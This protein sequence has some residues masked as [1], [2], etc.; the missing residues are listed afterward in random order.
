VTVIEILSYSNK[1][2][3]SQKRAR[4][5]LKRRELLSSGIH[6]MEIDLLRWGQRVIAT[7]PAKP[8]HILVSRAD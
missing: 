4:Y 3:G 7:L 8:Y 5:L 1:T 2:S 6:L